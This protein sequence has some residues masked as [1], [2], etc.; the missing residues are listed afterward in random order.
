M[1]VLCSDILPE[2]LSIRKV[3]KITSSFI[4]LYNPIL[5]NINNTIEQYLRLLHSDGKMKD[6][7]ETNLIA[8]IYKRAKNLK[9]IIGP[10]L[11]ARPKHTFKSVLVAVVVVVYAVLLIYTNKFICTVA[12]KKYFVKGE[13]NRKTN[14]MIYFR[15]KFKMQR[16]KHPQQ[17]RFLRYSKAF[18]KLMLL[19]T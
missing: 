4:S 15:N 11:Y 13:L 6:T 7:F 17:E 14:N 5:L 12:N 10:S 9:E 16:K 8:A 3:S 1:S 18:L 2:H 19:S